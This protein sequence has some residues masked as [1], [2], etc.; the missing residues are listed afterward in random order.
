METLAWKVHIHWVGG[1]V[2]SYQLLFQFSSV[3]GLD[4]GFGAGGEEL[5]EACVTKRANHKG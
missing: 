1:P 5:F 3:G 4:A 2:Q